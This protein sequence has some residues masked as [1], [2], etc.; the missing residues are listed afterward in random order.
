MQTLLNTV[1]SSSEKFHLNF[2][3]STTKVMVISKQPLDEP[4]ISTTANNSKIE[5]DQHCN[6]F[7]S[8]LTSD[9]TCEK[10]IGGCTNLVKSSFNNMKNVF[11]DRKLSI[12]LKTRLL[13]CFIWSVL[14]HS[15]ETWTLTTK[16]RKTQKQQKCDSV[17]EF[18]VFHGHHSKPTRQSFR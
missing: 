12:H 3:I 18:F 7:G 13:K 8:W 14:M 9:A 5:Q 17:I 1:Q 10:E 2:N 15:C 11:R 4:S 16:T 6:Y